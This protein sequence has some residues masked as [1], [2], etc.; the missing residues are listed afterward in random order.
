MMKLQAQIFIG[1]GDVLCPYLWP[2]L[3]AIR[4]W[5]PGMILH[6]TYPYHE[7]DMTTRSDEANARYFRSRGLMI[8]A[9]DAL[10]EFLFVFSMCIRE[11]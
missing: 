9:S 6:S 3:R 11:E 7:R 8:R 1:K 2:Y 4:T 5:R 10:R